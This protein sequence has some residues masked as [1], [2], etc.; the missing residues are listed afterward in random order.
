[1]VLAYLFALIPALAMALTQPV[2]SRVDEAQHVDFIIQLSHGVYPQADATLI[3]VQTLRLMESTGVYWIYYPGTFPKPDVTDMGPPPAG[4]S[5]RANAAWMSRHLW[6]LSYESTQT[7]GY[8]LAMVPIWSIA[9]RA[10]GTLLAVYVLRVVNALVLA[11]L[12]PMAWIVALRLAPGRSDIGWSS[13][14]LAALLPGAAFDGTRVSNDTVA[15]V[16]GAAAIVLAV[17]WVGGVWSWRRAGLMGALLGVALLVKLT[18]LGVFVP[19]GAAMLWPAAG[20]P[21]WRRVAVAAASF[22][23]AGAFLLPW[24]AV[25]HALYGSIFRGAR[26]SRLTPTLPEPFSLHFIPFDALFFTLSYWGGDPLGSLPLASGV[27]VLG[28][29]L[30]L[31]ATF[32]VARVAVAGKTDPAFAIALIAVAAVV[33]LALALPA[34]TGYQFAAP[35]RYA[36][37]GL[38]AIAPLTVIGISWA[39]PRVFAVRYLAGLYALVAVTALISEM[40]PQP[41]LE[42]G[43]QAPPASARLETAGVAGYVGGLILSVDQVAVDQSANAL[44]LGVTLRN[45]GAGEAEWSGTAMVTGS[46]G[47]A[48]SDYATSTHLPADIDP[49]QT[50]TGWLKVPLGSIGAGPG[51]ELS[52]RFPDVAADNYRVVEDVDLRVMV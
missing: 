46:G 39:L 42:S 47:T 44:W 27:I 33:G 11:L 17:R 23:L 51:R 40:V 18:L 50:V 19:V 49:G 48:W 1:M 36:L 29:L 9:D 2:W 5:A 41:A 37:P 22:G 13:V 6:Q 7:P 52:L 43:P 34:T 26:I 45:S 16:L 10:G 20:R 35:G 38:A 15:G 14:A 25:N 31:I 21:H 3:D 12:A 24:L 4:M 30:V 28:T 32:G 8:Y